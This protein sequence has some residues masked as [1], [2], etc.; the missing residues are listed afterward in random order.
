MEN[1]ELAVDGAASIR[2]I[3]S[4]EY[5]DPDSLTLEST[6]KML[7]WTDERLFGYVFEYPDS[8]DDEA[9]TD[10][11]TKTDWWN[12]NSYGYGYYKLRSFY[13]LLGG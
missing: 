6:Y 8:D 4:K 11:R 7:G 10:W 3:I 13:V 1:L 2:V 9:K 12:H 5:M